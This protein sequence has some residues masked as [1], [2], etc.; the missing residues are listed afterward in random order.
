MP[1]PAPDSFADDLIALLPNLRRFALSLARAG[2][3]A[4]DLV[5]ITVERALMARDRYDPAAR[6]DAWCFRILKNA[7]ID[8]TRRTRIR[9]VSVDVHDTP[10]AAVTSGTESEDRLM[11][12]Q[13]LGAMAG[14][15]DDHREVLTLVCL[16][17]MSYAEAAEVIGVPKGTVMSRLAR[18][19]A[20]LAEKLG[21]G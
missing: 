7:W 17:E 8:M 14:L 10:E 16:E 15:S 1:S 9:G 4:D 12:D 11:V 3:V 5:Q 21:I 19:R 18:A 20:A 6:L 13:V 2:D